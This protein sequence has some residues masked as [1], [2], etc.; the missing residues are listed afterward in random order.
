MKYAWE[1]EVRDNETDLQGIV[2]NANYFI[3]MA[4]AR[5]KHMRALG[6]DFN[7]M[8][9]LG[10]DLVLVHTDITFKTSLKSGDEFI[11]TSQ[12]KL[13]SRI[14]LDFEQEVIRKVDSK[15]VASAINTGVCLDI[16]RNRPVMPDFL[17]IVLTPYI[18]DS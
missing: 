1:A 5:H 14:R 11:V 8:H 4:H 7:A 6:I 10:F 3:Y 12:L 15:V 18:T 2:N 13:S 16:K 9:Q 17:K